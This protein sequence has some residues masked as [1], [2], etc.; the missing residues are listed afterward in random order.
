MG[1]VVRCVCADAYS[2]EIYPYNGAPAELG[3]GNMIGDGDPWE[4]VMIMIP[5]GSRTNLV[6]D[7]GFPQRPVKLIKR[8]L[9]PRP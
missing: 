5:S 2:S 1:L 7:E 6:G 9:Q 8:K 3:Y 4:E